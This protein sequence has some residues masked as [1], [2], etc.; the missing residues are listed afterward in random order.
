[1][2]EFRKDVLPEIEEILD[3]N[4]VQYKFHQTHKY[5]KFPW[6][7]S[8][9]VVD[10]ATAEKRI[11]GP[12]WGYALINEVSLISK[13]RYR[14]VIG[15]VRVKGT[16]YPQI[17]SVGTPEG[18]DEW[19]DDWW[20]NEDVEQRL[21]NSR[22]I[23]GDTRDNRENLGGD[24]IEALEGS[25]DPQMLDAY[26]RGL[27]VNMT[28]DRFYYSYDP[29]LNDDTSIKYNPQLPVMALID[30]NV[31]PMCATLCQ[32][33][34]T[35]SNGL[36]R[37]VDH[38][39]RPYREVHAFDEIRLE[40]P[41]GHDTANLSAA[42][43]AKGLHPESTILYPDPAGNARSTK[44]DIQRGR[45]DIEILRNLGWFQIKVKTKAPNMRGRRLATNNVLSRGYFK[46]HPGMAKGLKKDLSKN[47]LCRITFGK[48][49]SDLTQTHFS[50][51]FDYFVDWEYP[52]SGKK[53][54]RSG[55]VQIR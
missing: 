41:E 23:T 55:S 31:D 48:V 2:P 27:M 22:I 50:D 42:M 53:P 13:Y 32:I 1:M 5:F 38:Q 15:R 7:G 6:S 39:G 43:Y 21:P 17:A 37:V 9:G 16:K 54:S 35:P 24:Y 28:S 51:G 47:K 25:Y 44:G 49:K 18:E 40:G 14:E 19:I 52:L 46:L 3:A 36:I 29:L 11:R 26:M 34:E 45:S 8:R 30:F 33:Q 10:V 12:N 4:N 20:N